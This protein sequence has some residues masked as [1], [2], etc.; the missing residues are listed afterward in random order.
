MRVRV[1]VRGYLSLQGFFYEPTILAD[2]QEG[3]RIVDEEQ[4]GPVMPL[5]KYSDVDD[6][7]ARANDTDFG[8]GGSVCTILHPQHPPSP[9]PPPA[10]LHTPRRTSWMVVGLR[11]GYAL[12]LL[13]PPPPLL[14]PTLVVV[15]GRTTWKRVLSSR[16]RSRPVCAA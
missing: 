13:P 1:C 7:M 16:P 15:Q 5:I 2:V 10:V 6:A 12:L 11:R 4:F 9:L 14:L 3:V 8:L